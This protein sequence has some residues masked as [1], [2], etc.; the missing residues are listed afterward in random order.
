MRLAIWAAAPLEKAEM[1]YA[2]AEYPSLCAAA[3]SLSPYRRIHVRSVCSPTEHI[4]AQLSASHCQTPE[5]EAPRMATLVSLLWHGSKATN[6]VASSG[7][8]TDAPDT[9]RVEIGL[10][11][12]YLQHEMLK[13]YW[14]G[15]KRELPYIILTLR[16]WQTHEVYRGTT[17]PDEENHLIHG[18]DTF[19]DQVSHSSRNFS[20]RY[21][22]SE[23]IKDGHPPSYAQALENRGWDLFA[24]MRSAKIKET[25]RDILDVPPTADIVRRRAKMLLQSAQFLDIDKMIEY[26]EPEKLLSFWK[27]PAPP[28][29]VALSCDE[30]S[31]PVLAP[32]TCTLC[33]KTIRSSLFRGIKDDAVVICETCYR[34][35]HYG[36]TSFTKCHKTCC[37]PEAITPEI[38]RKICHC[39]G[40]R[41]RD[42]NG[43]LRALWPV[44]PSA[45]GGSHI[46]G[47]PGKVNCGLAQLTDMVAEAKYAATRMTAESD[48]TLED[49][50]RKAA[51]EMGKIQDV[52]ANKRKQQRDPHWRLDKIKNNMPTASEFGSSQGSTINAPENIPSYLRGITDSYPYGNVHM[53]L[54]IGPLVIENGVA[55]DPPELQVLRDA[56]SDI[57]HSLLLTGKTERRLYSQ[58]RQRVPKRYKA[59]MKQVV[60]GAFCGFFDNAAEE[61]ILDVLVDE[62]QRLVDEGISST[63]K[64][65][66]LE[67]S[68]NRLF[69]KIK[70]YLS[71]RIEQY[72]ESVATRLLDPELELRWNFRTNNCQTFCDNLIDRSLFGALFAPHEPSE[73]STPTMPLYLMS[74]VCRPGAYVPEKASSKFD[75]PNGLTEE[76]LLKFKYGRHDECDV[77][78]TLSEYWHDWGAFGGHLYP[79]QDLFPWDCTEAY[80]RYPIKC[81]E[82]N[83]AKHV[84]AFP[85]DSYSIISHHLARG[86]HFYPQKSEPVHSRENS[87]S[88]RSKGASTGQMSDS[89]WFRN[90]LTVLLAQDTLLRG[91]AAM[92]SC[93]V[94]RESTTWIHMQ[95][96]E[97]QDRLKLGGIH[98]A[99][100]FSHHF[101]K[102]Q[103]HQY[104]IASWAPLALP[105][106]IKAYESMREWRYLRA[107]SATTWGE[108]R[109]ALDVSEMVVWQPTAEEMEVVV[110]A[111]GEEAAVEEA[112]GEGEEEEE[113]G[114]VVVVEEVAVEEEDK[115]ETWERGYHYEAI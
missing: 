102:G 24:E 13:M 104:F 63:E 5:N 83:I 12:A 88:P 65:A 44:D 49:Q 109:V 31:M 112:E 27:R 76:Y 19:L 22:P 8:V 115:K 114:V 1:V 34:E 54:R 90:R 42:D 3:H 57:Q 29:L 96:D 7:H 79:Y 67:Q 92:A 32:E 77:I 20:K 84:W 36:Q 113:E 51:Q 108:T 55:K 89:D 98:R 74:F 26:R 95:E 17:L 18:F 69:V 62:S 81:N 52:E 75:V 40:V 45:D 6:P 82:C 66:L 111:V 4:Q 86:R 53:A 9:P 100:P 37:L 97:R 47:G 14:D 60:G 107:R 85:F 46:W 70:P 101:D 64:N 2:V 41:R 105:L 68:T 56:P 10:A 106:K 94:F 16:K 103:Y 48:E 35:K 39:T 21:I 72:I 59:L 99:Q 25:I 73:T 30:A 110:T 61:D 28:Q 33:R 38:S 78:D 11:V 23:G 80:G 15:V 58:S 93:N 91:A 71:K 87:T 50:Q 43:K